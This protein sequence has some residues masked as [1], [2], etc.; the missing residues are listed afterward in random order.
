MKR[1]D[2]PFTD[3]VRRAMGLAAR[4]AA[5]SGEEAVTPAHM[6]A[7]LLAMEH[8]V[9]RGMLEKL[10]VDAAALAD[11]FPAVSSAP[12][13]R[14]RVD[15]VG[16]SR[17]AEAVV[18]SA[19]RASRELRAGHVGTEHLLL[20]LVEAGGKEVSEALR[21][22]GLRPTT[23]RLQ[24]LRQMGAPAGR[25]QEARLYVL[26]SADLLRVPLF[27]A[28]R[29]LIEGGAD[30]I[31]YRDKRLEDGPFLANARVLRQMTREAEV[32]F[33]INDRVDVALL[34][35]ADGVHLG[36]M[37]LSVMQARRLLGPTRI[38]GVSTHNEQEAR[39]SLAQG[40]DYIAVGSIFPTTTKEGVECAGLPYLTFVLRELQPD[41]PVYPIG[42]ITLENLSQVLAVGADRVAVASAVVAQEDIRKACAAFKEALRSIG[43]ETTP[44]GEGR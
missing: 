18:A 8:S 13:E 5:L 23:L 38:I 42:G 37:D 4:F 19:L 26:L 12:G 28:A 30:V 6:L 33:L 27:E 24:I 11:L 25:L 36:Q 10:G 29:A 35:E 31:Q 2:A 14:V 44:A 17:T 15:R 21:R 3:R 40:P 7:G 16:Y 20:A 34:A 9:A 41:C 22:A 43:P 32:L 39:R 1:G